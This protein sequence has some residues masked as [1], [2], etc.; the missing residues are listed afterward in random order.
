MS[1]GKYCTET[2]IEYIKVVCTNWYLLLL[3]CLLST[4]TLFSPLSPVF[5]CLLMPSAL[6]F[7]LS[8][9]FLLFSSTLALPKAMLWINL[10][11]GVLL[12]QGFSFAVY[13]PR[14][15]KIP[16]PPHSKKGQEDWCGFCRASF[17]TP[18]PPSPPLLFSLAFSSYKEMEREITH[19]NCML[20]LFFSCFWPQPSLAVPLCW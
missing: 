16:H 15:R 9:F 8:P 14:W 13:D 1:A 11:F 3:A 18:P 17:T 5:S 6:S 4:L 10:P 19:C 12:Y 7:S 20:T 2:Y